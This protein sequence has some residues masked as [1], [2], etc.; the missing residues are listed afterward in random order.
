MQS[1]QREDRQYQFLDLNSSQSH[2]S[3]PPSWLGRRF[4]RNH[5]ARQA[6]ERLKAGAVWEGD[7]LGARCVRVRPE[8]RRPAHAL[9]G[10]CWRLPGCRSC[11]TMNYGTERPV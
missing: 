4:L 8:A 11:D 2:L 7:R 6:E 1:L 9:P 3:D 10:D 5:R